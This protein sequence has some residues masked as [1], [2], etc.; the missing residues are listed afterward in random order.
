MQR[1]LLSLALVFCLTATSFAESRV[2]RGSWQSQS[3]GHSGA[4]RITPQGDG[5][6]SAVLA[7][8]FAKVIPFVYRSELHPT[9]NGTYQSNKQLGPILGEYRMQATINGSYFNAAFQAAGDQGSFTMK[10]VK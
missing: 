7:G 1:I 8:R 2:Y 6:Y 3:T 10:R 9:A 4:M 5:S